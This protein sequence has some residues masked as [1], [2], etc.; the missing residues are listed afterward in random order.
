MAQN[1][2]CGNCGG[3]VKL[4]AGY[5]KAKIRCENCGYYAEVPPGQRSAAL[6]DD[7]ASS[8]PSPSPPR[9]N[10]RESDSDTAPAP[11][12][13]PASVRRRVDPRDH[14]PEFVTEEGIGPPLLDGTQE[15]DDGPYRVHGTGLKE[16]P[17]CRGELPLDATFCVHC[18]QS[19]IDDSA[20][21]V[22]KKRSY[23]VIDETYVQ[24][25][26]IQ[27]R[28]ALFAAAQ[29][30]NVLFTVLS[31][32]ANDWKVDS[33]SV[34]TGVFVGLMQTALQAFILGSFDTINV[35]RDER[36]KAILTRNRRIAFIPLQ[37]AKIKWRKSV[38]VGRVA[39]HGGGILAWITCLYLFLCLF[40]VPGI[41]FW[42][43]ELKPDRYDVVLCDLYGGVEE[44]VFRARDQDE[45]ETVMRVVSEATTLKNRGVV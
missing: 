31:V 34:G 21:P 7:E 3:K 44:F 35:H 20:R 9:L 37:Q 28:F 36:G 17:E 23:S 1:I 18:G 24:G 30:L 40:C 38:G 2:P 10:R 39:T 26:S 19:L 15:D 27:T 41:L 33:S 12:A 22:R 11:P 16:C 42:W 5:S 43:F 14:R 6:P 13:K 25:W 29:L 4:P 32:A 45:A 8:T